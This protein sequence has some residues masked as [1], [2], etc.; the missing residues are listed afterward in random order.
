MAIRMN[1]KNGKAQKVIKKVITP[2]VS[3][4]K[5][6]V[7][8][9]KNFKIPKVKYVEAVGRRKVAT[10]RVRIYEGQGDFV[11]NDSLVSEYFSSLRNAPAL[12]M[13]P[14]DLTGN[15]GKFSVTAKV[16]GS[17]ISAQLDALTNG[18]A[19][20]LV[21]FNPELRTFL[22]PAGLLTRDDRMKETRKMGMGGKARRKRQSPKR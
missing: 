14:F 1:K 5:K 11:V 2:V 16:S 21:A 7:E 8:V 18:L 6:G 20:A 3:V 9:E 13:K 4:K 12:Y 19:K 15:K 22:K 10:A 17:G